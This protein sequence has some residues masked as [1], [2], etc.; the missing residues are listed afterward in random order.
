VEQFVRETLVSG[1][2]T[3]LKLCSAFRVHNPGLGLNDEALYSLLGFALHRELSFRKRL[4]EFQTI[5][6][7]A[8]LLNSA[9]NIIVITGAGISTS[10]GIPDFRSKNTGFYSKLREMGIPDPESLFTLE[11]FDFDPTSFYKLAGDLLPVQDTWSPTHQFIKLLQDK[12]KLLR[13]YT[14][15]IDNVE[16]YAGV[17]E[18]KIIHCHGSWKTAT[19][20][21]CKHKV[22]GEQLFESLKAQKVARCTKC[23][24]SLNVGGNAMKRKRSYQGSS[25]PRKKGDFEDDSS[26]DDN[27]PEPGVMKPDITFFGENLPDRFYDTLNSVDREAVDL[28]IVIGTSMK[29]APVS[30]IPQHVKN[31]VPQ[32]MISRDVS[33][34]ILHNIGIETNRVR[35]AY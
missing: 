26:E 3:A 17:N 33:I 4:D 16:S 13:N 22:P 35:I 27:I 9:K 14:Q 8:K 25:K 29:V 15:N 24:E 30:E 34:V 32:I 1:R 20:R 11:E 2:Y 19:C 18:D 10:L 12:G 28:I 7:A 5:D 21:K 31:S 6:D 23:I